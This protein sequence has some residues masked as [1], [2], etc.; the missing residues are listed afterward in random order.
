MI[1]THESFVLEDTLGA[2]DLAYIASA[3]RTSYW[4][5]ER[6]PEITRQAFASSIGFVLRDG[7]RPIGCARVVT[8]GVWFSWLC[9]VWVDASYR[10]QGLGTWMVD[11]VLEHPSVCRTRVLLRTHDAQAFYARLGFTPAEVWVRSPPADR[12]DR[13]RS[14]A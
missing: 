8:D 3:L 9:D 5:A 10:G 2:S 7:S 13:R 14:P 12:G 4:S 11:R 1:A 6:A